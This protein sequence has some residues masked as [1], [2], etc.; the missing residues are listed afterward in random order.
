[1]DELLQRNPE[2][3]GRW[4]ATQ[5]ATFEGD[6]GFLDATG[7]TA[8]NAAAS[9]AAQDIMSVQAEGGAF[10]ADQFTASVETGFAAS[11]AMADAD[12]SRNRYQQST[13]FGDP[14]ALREMHELLDQGAA[15]TL[16]AAAA[17][18]ADFGIGM[19]LQE[20]QAYWEA[21]AA[22]ASEGGS[23]EGGP[24]EG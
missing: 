20:Q 5:A 16:A 12:M 11:H 24:A 8:A 4:T 6:T 21:Q 7:V 23:G 3:S 14:A 10:T 22:A 15:G 1:M 9:A 17:N 19:T 13:D 2:N 18:P